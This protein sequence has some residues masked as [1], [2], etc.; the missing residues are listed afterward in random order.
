M[1]MMGWYGYG[2]GALL[3]MRLRMLLWV[4]VIGLVVWA[5][6]PLA[7]RARARRW[8]HA[9]LHSSGPLGDRDSAPALGAWRERRRHL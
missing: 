9:A 1:P 8:N 7:G 3:L 6:R 5:T 2:W 4:L